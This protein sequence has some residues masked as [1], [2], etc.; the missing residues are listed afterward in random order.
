MQ[1]DQLFAIQN[2][3]SIL[4]E[5]ILIS[6]LLVILVLDLAVKNSSWLSGISLIG[7]LSAS[8][9]LCLQWRNVSTISIFLGSLEIDS[10]S[11]TFRLII[12]LCSA[13]CI[14]ISTEYIQ[15]S[16]MALA[17]FLTFLLAAT[18][19]G[20]FLCSANDLVTIFVTLECLSFSSYLLAGYAKKDIRSNEAAMKYLLIGGASSS[21][22]LYGFSW[23]YGLS[24]GKLKLVELL[25]GI[26]SYE[27][28]SLG[29]WIAF[30][31]VIVGIGFKIS[32]VPFHQWT[33]DVYEGSPTPVVAFLSVGSKAAGLAIATRIFSTVFSFIEPEWHPTFELLSLLSMIFGNLI[34]ANQ[35]SIKRM[36]AYSSISQVGYIIIGL[37][38][39]HP[40]GY[41]SMT[42]YMLTYT[43]M[44]L[45]AFACVIVFGLRSGT[46]QIRD[47]AGL[48][49]KDPWLAFSLTVCLLSLAGI[50]PFAGFF[51]KVYLFWSGWNKG[52]YFLVYIGLLTSVISMYY[53]LRVIK[54]MT[55]RDGKDMS[56]YVQEYIVSSGSLDPSSEGILIPS[57]IELGLT[58]CVIASIVLGFFMNPIINIIQQSILSSNTLLIL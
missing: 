29:I 2:I 44:N 15:R 16:G 13:L 56:V 4:P 22:L 3:I 46:D 28:F 10:F 51:G 40:D 49:F 9:V 30:T 25:E 52:L 42:T 32:A 41:A 57:S 54:I 5:I 14:L 17:E 26:T 38:A 6:C 33:P 36:L 27:S 18:I 20:M 19:G 34:A 12:T 21:I 55:T 1:F 35:T 24:G 53:Y 43:F 11:I 45:G 48:Y 37:V 8:I 7:L 31:C 58:L 50:P 47:Y 39:G 23:L